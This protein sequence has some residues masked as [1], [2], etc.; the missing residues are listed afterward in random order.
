MGEGIAKTPQRGFEVLLGRL[1][2]GAQESG[3]LPLF[4][5]G[6]GFTPAMV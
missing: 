5:L 2:A 1:G 3:Y 6:Q 4:G